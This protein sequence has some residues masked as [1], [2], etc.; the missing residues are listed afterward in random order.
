MVHS[1]KKGKRGEVE[2]CEFIELNFGI[3]TDRVYNQAD[4]Y[5]SDIVI[6]D[7]VFEVKRQETLHLLD[8]WNQSIVACNK[9][10]K[11]KIP[12]VAFRQNRKPWS[13]L[14]SAQLLGLEKGFI[15]LTERTFINYA[16]MVIHND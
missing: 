6:N 4:G 8:W 2:F 14:L 16:R 10:Y 3:S 7:F 11:N 12:V 9:K 13:F 1:Q 15:Q 5:S